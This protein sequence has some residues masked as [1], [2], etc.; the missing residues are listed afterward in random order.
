MANVT[1]KQEVTLGSGVLYLVEATDDVIPEHEAVEIDANKI[2]HLDGDTELDYEVEW[3][4]VEDSLGELVKSFAIKEKGIFKANLLSWNNNVLNK[5]VE[6]GKITEDVE[7]KTRKLEIGGLEN[8]KNQLYVLRFVHTKDTGKKIRL[9]IKGKNQNG[10][11]LV[12]GE[13]ATAIPV[14]FKAY[15]LNTD[16]RI[17]IVEEEVE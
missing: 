11:K 16:K 3:K 15:S 2:G 5:L 8:A 12:F 17:I 4:E 13:N 10:L 7:K 9:T 6:N 1:D 14:E